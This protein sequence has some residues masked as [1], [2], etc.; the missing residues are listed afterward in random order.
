MGINFDSFANVRMDQL[1]NSKK[2]D[3]EM[4]QYGVLGMKWGVRK[5]DRA[6]QADLNSLSITPLYE[7]NRGTSIFAKSENTKTE[8]DEIN[9]L[10]KEVKRHF[11]EDPT[12]PIHSGAL[13]KVNQKYQSIGASEQYY[14]EF[15]DTIEKFIA[16]N[17]PKGLSVQVELIDQELYFAI[18]PKD[19][20]KVLFPR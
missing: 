1:E 13:A 4:E 8:N 2:F 11:L 14:R 5:D 15:G 10:A 3:S 18:G 16:P 7:S 12:S 6:T 9:S 19:M 20:Q 17:L